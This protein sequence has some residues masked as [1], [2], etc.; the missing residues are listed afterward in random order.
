M[1]NVDM[2]ALAGL[3]HDIG[4]FGQRA[5]IEL[6]DGIYQ[7]YDYRYTHARYTAQILNELSFNLG[8]EFS[9]ISATHHNPKD[10]LSWIIA[11]ADRMASGFERETF[12]EYNEK[13]DK[14]DFKKQRL[15]YL[16]DKNKRYKI[17][18]LKP[19]NIMPK[20][21]RAVTNEYKELWEKFEDDLK[22]IKEKGKSIVDSFTIDYI[23]KK[24][25]S[26]IPSSTTFKLKDYAPVKA[27][28][29]LYEHSK[30]T[31][32]FASVI[33]KLY[34][35]NNHNIT[36]YYKDKSGDMEQN[37]MLLIAGD[38]FGIQKFIFDSVPTA[39]ASKILRAKSAYIQILTKTIAFYIVERLE[40]SHQSIITT[41]AGKFEILGVNDDDTKKKL[42]E[43]RKE[44]DSFF[45]KEYFGESG[46]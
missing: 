27:N 22:S 32:V 1:K 40:L 44:L 4:K 36:N 25:T 16:F 30:A 13:S 31:A 28:I 15:W 26:F 3:L 11:S 29:P 8:D 2:I 37:D 46:L 9:D 33:Y 41:N 7:Q 5:G 24:Y 6:K 17:D 18:V 42:K 10:D 43:I 19:E 23:L 38:F 45:I 12:E 39:K 20:D 34:E 14:E 21:D 35:K